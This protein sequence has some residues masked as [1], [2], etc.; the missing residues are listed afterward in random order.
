MFAARFYAIT[1]YPA[2]YFAKVGAASAGI[3]AAHRTVL[4]ARVRTF[5]L[6]ARVRRWTL[7]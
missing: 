2:R 1:Y 3:V 6:V 7:C 5:A 4:A